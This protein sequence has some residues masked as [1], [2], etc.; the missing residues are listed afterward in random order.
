V[1]EVSAQKVQATVVIDEAHLLPVDVLGHLHILLNYQR[2]SRP[3]LSLLLIGLPGLRERLKR[4][5]LTSL[6]ARL[7]MRIHLDPLSSQ[8]V[9]EYLRHR[10]RMAGCNDEVFAEDAVLLI[11]EATGGV[12]RKIDVLASRA[13]F[14]ACEGKSKLVDA[15]VVGDAVGLCGESLV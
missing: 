14:L 10:M 3:L 1:E 9:G 8:Q 6:A 7:P 2:D 13:L 4:N 15:S 12:M 11:A 5:V